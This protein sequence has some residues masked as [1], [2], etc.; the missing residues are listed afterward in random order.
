[1]K[2]LTSLKNGADTKLLNIEAQLIP[3]RLNSDIVDFQP[4]ATVKLILFLQGLYADTLMSFQEFFQMF[5]E[6]G[7][8]YMKVKC[9]SCEIN[10]A[11][12]FT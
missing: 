7:E 3:P 8:A 11:I 4:K 9:N 12:D 2:S 5:S 10:G 1:M 6:F